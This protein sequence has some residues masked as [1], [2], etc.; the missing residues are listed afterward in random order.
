MADVQ[1]SNSIVYITLCNLFWTNLCMYAWLWQQ[2][3]Y[4]CYLVLTSYF[5]RLWWECFSLKKHVSL[6][7]HNMFFNSGINLHIVIKINMHYYCGNHGNLKQQNNYLVYNFV[8]ELVLKHFICSATCLCFSS[9][10]LGWRSV[11][12][13]ASP[14]CWRSHRRANHIHRRHLMAWKLS[15]SALD[16]PLKYIIWMA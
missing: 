13:L 9:Q 14:A 1:K 16:N 2:Q 10:P 3:N 4:V 6:F 7:H 12:P 5:G 11:P 8:W 15:S